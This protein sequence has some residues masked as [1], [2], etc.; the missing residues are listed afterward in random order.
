MFIS[1][2][3]LRV[4]CV[5]VVSCIVPYIQLKIDMVDKRSARRFRLI[6]LQSRRLGQL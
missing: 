6:H 5:S 1:L 3:S 4:L 2:C